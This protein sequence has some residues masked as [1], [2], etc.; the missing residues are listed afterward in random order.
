M[1]GAWLVG[2]DV[3][4]RR[5]PRR[6]VLVAVRQG[7]GTGDRPPLAELRRLADA[8]GL[9]VVGVVVQTRA[10]PDPATY[11]SAGKV[12]ELAVT[13]QVARADVVI[14]DDD[15]SRRQTRALEE[16]TR[17]RV[18]DR[19]A[20]ILDIFGG[21]TREDGPVTLPVA[22]RPP[23]AV[24]AG[25][26]NAGKSMLLNRLSGARA[27]TGDGLF[28]TTAP[29]VREVGVDGRTLTLADTVGVV[30][31]LPY[32]RVDAFRS[33]IEAL[34]HADLTIHVADASAPDVL[35]QISTV[36][37]VRQE[38]G[39]G[40]VPELLVLNKIDVARPDQLDVLHHTYPD[41]VAVS[42]RTGEGIAELLR[43]VATRLRQLELGPVS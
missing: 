20:L 4:N 22:D 25:Y 41:P 8:D 28:A 9:T 42:A 7:D 6:T 13:A 43:T 36:H 17:T 16:R 15:L 18:V 37:A 30:R 33:T 32:R 19:T 27:R 35:D 12:A 38:I 34:R 3:A 1:A 5:V 21:H 31:H 11:L 2:T 26:A 40:R 39:A 23:C 29:V 24:I 10:R 14:A